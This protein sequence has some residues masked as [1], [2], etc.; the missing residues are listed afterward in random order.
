M[1]R[2]RQKVQCY[3]TRLRASTSQVLVFEHVDFPEAGIQVPGGSIDPGETASEAALREAW[4]ESGL[5][6]LRVKR[7]IGAFCWWYEALKEEHERHVFHLETS[8]PLP[9]RWQ[10]T[11]SA[12][13]GDKGLRF[14]YYWLD[15]AAA[16]HALSGDQ[17]EYLQYISGW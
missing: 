7:Y 17:G 9:E 2:P 6:G 8:Q 12:G 4:E 11:V 15:A 3:I 16:T 10:H 13:E 5:P 1:P 14:A